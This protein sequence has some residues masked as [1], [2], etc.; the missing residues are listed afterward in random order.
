VKNY[1][2]V[3]DGSTDDKAAINSAIAVA[4]STGQTVYFPPGEYVV[5]AGLDSITREGVTLRGDGPRASII[6]MDAATGNTVTLGTGAQFSS[7]RDLAFIPT[8]TTFRTSG[9]EILITGGFL[10]VVY[11]VYINYGYRGVSVVST[12][13]ALIDNLTMR[14]MTG[15]QGLTFEG[16]SGTPSYGLYVKNVVADNPYVTGPTATNVTG[17]FQATYGYTAN[18]LFTANGWVWQVTTAGTSGASG[19]AAPTTTSWWQTSVSNGAGTLMVRAICNTQLAWVYMNNYANSLTM[20]SAALLNGG[21]G[22]RM[23]DAANTGTSY[24][25]WAFFYDLEVDHSYTTGVSLIGGLGFH[26]TGSWIGSVLAGNGVDTS[27]NWLGEFSIDNSRVVGN[28]QN[29]ILVGVGSDSKVS[30]NFL[31]N[32]S[33]SSSGSYHGVSVAANINRFT[34]SDNSVGRLVGLG[35]TNQGYGVYVS[36]GTSDYYT[37]NGNLGEGASGNVTGTLY[38]GGT[39][40]NKSVAFGAI[41]GTGTAPTLGVGQVYYRYV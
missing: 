38:D 20:V 21:Y 13:S 3:G 32:N 36:A 31:C 30:N 10:N 5:S 29:G 23:A 4:N 16:T 6:R 12:A 11:N 9:A 22:F 26:A 28:A 15:D 39:G 27:S 7:V 34:I 8:G 37:L 1:G 17:A 35:S 33:T 14:Y 19:P 40:T 2:A 41:W 18:Q 25:S 24:P